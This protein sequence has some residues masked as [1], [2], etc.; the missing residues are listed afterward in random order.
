MK[1]TNKDMGKGLIF[2]LSLFLLSIPVNNLFNDLM[3]NF[4]SN[5]FYTMKPEGG[6]P[7]E[8]M[9][10]LGKVITVIGLEFNLIYVILDIV[11]GSTLYFGIY[12]FNRYL[13]KKYDFGKQVA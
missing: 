9:Y 11:L 5:Y 12:L 10:N 4:L 7:L 3:P 13:N 2:I 1:F 6:T 8:V